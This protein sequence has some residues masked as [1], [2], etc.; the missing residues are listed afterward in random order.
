MATAPLA[1]RGGVAMRTLSGPEEHHKC[2][3]LTV[4]VVNPLADRCGVKLAD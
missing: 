4:E 3:T 2:L 1:S